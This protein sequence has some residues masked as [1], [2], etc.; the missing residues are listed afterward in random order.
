MNP[1][2][3]R[4]V[5]EELLRASRNIE[6]SANS[7]VKNNPSLSFHYAKRT[8]KSLNNAALELI[9]SKK[10]LP[11]GGSGSMAQ[12]LQQLQSI[13]SGQ[14]QVNRGTQA[15]LPLDISLGS[16]PQEV[17]RELRRLSELQGSLAERLRRVMRGIEEEGGD[18]LG[19]LSKITEEMEDVVKKL[20]DYAI[21]RELVEREE[22][23]LSRML[24]AQRSVH[25]REFSKK[26]VAERPEKIIVRKPPPLPLN[27]G[28]KEGIRKDILRELKEKYP[29]EYRDLIRA[30]FNK[31]LEEERNQK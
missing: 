13:S 22:R 24:D 29:Q 26:R 23:I 18:I 28:E 27:L 25:K 20:S 31:L 11:S 17:Q 19:D 21:D 6:S 3:P 4:I 8:M 2:I 5:D 9:E 1:F 10:N 14:M 16:I 12:L 7:L 30:Y 15:L